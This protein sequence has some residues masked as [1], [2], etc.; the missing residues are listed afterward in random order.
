MLVASIVMKESRNIAV[1]V[2]LRTVSK[3]NLCPTV[4]SVPNIRVEKSYNKRYRTSH[5][6]NSRL[7]QAYGFEHFMEQQKARYTCPECGGII[8]I[9]DRECSECEE[10]MK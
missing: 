10:K 5:I 1:N 6:E 4:L 8:S 2:K 7:V 3:K 9:H